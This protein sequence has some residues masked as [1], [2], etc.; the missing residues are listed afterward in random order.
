MFTTTYASVY[1]ALYTDKDYP[2]ECDLIEGAL[3]RHGA[4]RT[5]R[6]VDLGC[7]TGSHAAILAERGYE[8]TGV[9]LS[10]DMLRRA[11]TKS[12]QVRWLL[13]D[14]RTIDAG[15]PFDA[16]LMMF[17][18]LSYQ[19]S[20]EDV[21]AA[22]ANARRHVRPGGLLVL[23]TWWGPAVVAEGPS[24]RTKEAV[25]DDGSLVTRSARAELDIE[26]RLCRVDYLIERQGRVDE[27]TH[28]VRFFFCNELELL[29]KR[30]GFEAL[31]FSRFGTLDEDPDETTWSVLVVGR[32]V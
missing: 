2:A 28:V 15:G 13:G 8:L 6:I 3:E 14:V 23:D 26:R 31:S 19:R 5:R 7:G 29:L 20:N 12:S 22:L 17:A 11:R 4:T 25:D 9:D 27:E 16:A 1:D 21:L 24:E 18:V 32:A 30:A 10:P